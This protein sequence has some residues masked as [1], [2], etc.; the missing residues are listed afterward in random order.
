MR[1]IGDQYDQNKEHLPSERK[2]KM[3]L[4]PKILDI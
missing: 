1:L 3:F 2:H 4:T